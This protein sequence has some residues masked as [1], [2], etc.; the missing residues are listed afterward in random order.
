M[1]TGILTSMADKIM[2]ACN[3]RR[4]MYVILR[5]LNNNQPIGRLK[6]QKRLNVYLA[7]PNPWFANNYNNMKY[8]MVYNIMG[9][10]IT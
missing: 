9:C 8:I 4:E 5:Q 6:R 10:L 1:L 7:L 3:Y 2:F